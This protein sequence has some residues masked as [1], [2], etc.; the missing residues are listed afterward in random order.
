MDNIILDKDTLNIKLIDF[1]FACLFDPVE[2]MCERVGTIMYVAPEVVRNCKYSES[3]DMW[4][5]GIVTFILLTGRFP[6]PCELD[7]QQLEA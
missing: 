2:G 3:S 1:G 5:I 7:P 6:F 4:S